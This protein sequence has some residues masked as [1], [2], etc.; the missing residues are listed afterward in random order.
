MTKCSKR[1]L[2]GLIR[3][4]QYNGMANSIDWGG[5]LGLGLNLNSATYKMSKY[6]SLCSL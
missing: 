1:D 2:Q 4:R 6:M 5:S 3:K